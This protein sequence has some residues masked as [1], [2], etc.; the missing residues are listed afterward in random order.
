MPNRHE[1]FC[2][3]SRN[4]QGVKLSK[5]KFYKAIGFT[6]N[7]NETKKDNTPLF[8]NDLINKYRK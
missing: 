7:D 2:S 6:E 1:L 3:P 4:G 5:E 8:G